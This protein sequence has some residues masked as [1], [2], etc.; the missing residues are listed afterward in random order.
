M[1]QAEAKPFYEYHPALLPQS[2]VQHRAHFLWGQGNVIDIQAPTNTTKHK[3]QQ[4]SIDG[5]K[6]FSSLRHC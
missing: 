4:V 1:R 2:E 6:H 3:R 5:Q